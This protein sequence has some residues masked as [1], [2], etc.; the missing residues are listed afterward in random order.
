VAAAVVA[1]GRKPRRRIADLVIAATAIADG[2]PLY[3]TNPR[4]LRG[5][6]ATSG[7]CVREPFGRCQIGTVPHVRKCGRT[8]RSR[9]WTE[10][11]HAP[12]AGERQGYADHCYI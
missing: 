10:S 6:V 9:L 4:R 7:A 3:A 12:N 1:A 2:L 8:P 5:K 11:E